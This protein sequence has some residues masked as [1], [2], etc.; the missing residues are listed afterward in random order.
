MSRVS[1]LL[2][3]ATAVVVAGWITGAAASTVDWGTHDAL[4]T[5]SNAPFG[6]VGVGSTAFADQY[7]FVMPATSTG[8]LGSAVSIE[9][10][11]G[12]FGIDGG[13]VSL[14]HDLTPFS[15][16]G[17]DTFLS[18]FAFGPTTGAIFHAFAGLIAGEHYYYQVSGTG[19]TAGGLYLLTS[20]LNT[21]GGDTP[22]PGALLLMGSAVGGAGL[23]SRWR[24]RK[25][26]LATA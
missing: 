8:T 19:R 11:T 21:R 12:I 18:S 17:G 20:T 10:G 7:L 4:E 22:I 25:D 6:P 26:Q 2:G 16:G 1:K 24:K 3:V 15:V 13:M 23:F 9:A 14:F 5:G